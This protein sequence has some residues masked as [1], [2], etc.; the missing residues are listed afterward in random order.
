MTKKQAEVKES[1]NGVDLIWKG[2][3]NNFQTCDALQ[4]EAEEKSL[5]LLDKQKEMLEATRN[6]L[7]KVEAQAEK[8]KSDW[9]SNLQKTTNQTNP[10]LSS[11]VNVVEDVNDKAQ[12]L[13]WNPTRTMLD[14]FSQTQEQLAANY[15]EAL[16]VQQQGRK[17]A[18]QS[19][20]TFTEQMKQAQKNLL[21]SIGS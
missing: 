2:W 21:A 4:H 6:T 19:L 11:W 16:Q 5:Q 1:Q 17:E 13:T 15:K 7:D 20:E 10:F 14:Y 9:K 12:T 18:V 8:V 3:L